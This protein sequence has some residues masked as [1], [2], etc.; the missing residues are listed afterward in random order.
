MKRGFKVFIAAFVFTF[1]CYHFLLWR[2]KGFVLVTSD[3]AEA[4]VQL[5]TKITSPGGGR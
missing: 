5:H 3:Y 4:S 1:G 2:Q